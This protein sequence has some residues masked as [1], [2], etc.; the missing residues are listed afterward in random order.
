MPRA[1]N[2]ENAMSRL[3]LAVP[4]LTVLGVLAALPAEA[5]QRVFVAS[6]GNDANVATGCLFTQPCR[7]FTAAMTQVDPGGEV[8][9]LDAAGY[10]AV[11]ITK[12]VT[13]TANPGFYAGIS[14]GSGNGV[15]IATGGV[16]V[17]LRNL[18]INGVGAT[19]GVVMTAGSQLSI[20]NCVIS[21]F[22]LGGG[23]GVSV[24]TAATVRIVDSLVRENFHGVY[25]ANGSTGTIAR[26]KFFGNTEAGLYVHGNLGGATTA[27]AVSDS[28]FT[29]PA[30]AIYT[31][32]NTGAAIARSA[33]TR[34]TLSNNGYGI[35]SEATSGTAVSTI[36]GS[37]ISGNTFGYSVVGAGSSVE[38][39]GNNT[40]RQNAGNTGAL[41]PVGLE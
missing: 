23:K 1:S 21:N 2:K 41:T 8:V 15:T 34:S 11:T 5:A 3:S 20:E 30:Y 35:A 4:A 40:F 38:T 31:F 9:A 29:N 7:G 33:V 25:L 26:T 19:N 39:L 12:S 28:V 32:N 16:K 6:T 22:S 17:T 10:G 36:S 24:T 13:I 37:M 27:A 18:N 14:A